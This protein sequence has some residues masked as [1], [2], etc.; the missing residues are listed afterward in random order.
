MVT[1]ETKRWNYIKIIS[2]QFYFTC[3]HCINRAASFACVKVVIL[4]TD[5]HSNTNNC[6]TV[7]AAEEL[8]SIGA[9]IYIVANGEGPQL[10][11]L[12][13]IASSPDSHYVLQLGDIHHVSQTLLD[14][15]C[16]L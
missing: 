4:V 8:K 16:N 7:P 11:E 15:L 13:Q 6:Q 5:G 9:N 1:C 12:T 3:D 2:K 14:R 10:S